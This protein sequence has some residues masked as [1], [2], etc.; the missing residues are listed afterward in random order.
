MNIEPTPHSPLFSR[1]QG[2]GP[3]VVCLHSSSGSH[4][5]WRG[6]TDA[7]AGRCQTIAPDLFGH[8]RSPEWPMGYANT[9]HVDAHGV[10]A[11]MRAAAG[12]LATRGI[13]LVGHS[14]GGAVA[15]Q[16]AL[17]HPRWVRS[18]TLYEPVPFGVMRAMAP[19]DAALG[20]IEDIAHSVEAMVN[21]NELEGAARIFVGYWGG[22]SAWEA[23]G[24]AQRAAVAARIATV[25]RHFDALFRANWNP[26]VLGS[27]NMPILLM[28]GSKSRLP[29]RRVA[30]L[31]GHALPHLQRVEV[32]GA[33]HL[34]PMTHER[35]V[36]ARMLAFL[37][38]NAG[39]PQAAQATREDLSVLV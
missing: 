33:G 6:L 9:L 39:L 34:G 10:S 31:L 15:M 18:L 17:H 32:A 7:L 38:A 8:G 12:S 23:L 5:Q 21:R 20:E 2:S 14:Y 3:T 30:E 4:A 28:R 19:A 13:H 35:E 26:R 11:L 22:P 27:L 16:I 1:T 24:P 37:E 25:P 36:T 29:A